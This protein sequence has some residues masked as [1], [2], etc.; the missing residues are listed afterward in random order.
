[1]GTRTA[2]ATKN[3][4]RQQKTMTLHFDLVK[5]TKGAHQYKERAAK[6]GSYAMGTA[7]IR[8]T[9]LAL[10]GDEAP[11]SIEILVKVKK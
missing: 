11:E 2:N 6:D 10:F 4:T 3:P 8:K 7:Y 5:E 1:M 9:A